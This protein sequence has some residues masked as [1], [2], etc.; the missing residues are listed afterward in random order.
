MINAVDQLST[1]V[2]NAAILV[3]DH[4]MTNRDSGNLGEERSISKSCVIWRVVSC[5]DLKI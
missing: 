3:S 2:H 1:Y 4:K 5:L